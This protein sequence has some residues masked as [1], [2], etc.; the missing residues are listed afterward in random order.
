[1]IVK[2]RD[3]I[4]SMGK[5]YKAQEIHD[6]GQRMSVDEL[7]RVIDEQDDS[8]VILDMRNNYE[9]KLGHFKGA[10]PAGTINF[11]ELED[12]C[13]SYKKAFA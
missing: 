4:V 12:Y 9:W 5:I 7:K 3:E 13:E 2:H 8:Y 1:M 11:K 6:G 10:L